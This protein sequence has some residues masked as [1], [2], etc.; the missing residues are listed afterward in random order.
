MKLTI[1]INN[2]VYSVSTPGDDVNVEQM[3]EHIKGLLVSAGFHPK[4]VDEMFY[5]DAWSWFPETYPG[6]APPPHDFL[7][8]YEVVGTAGTVN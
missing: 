3:Q 7:E 1:E 2:N 5:E 8:G 4:S 6:G